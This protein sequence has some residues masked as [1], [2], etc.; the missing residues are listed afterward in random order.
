MHIQALNFIST[1]KTP[2]AVIRDG[3]RPRVAETCCNHNKEDGVFTVR[4]YFWWLLFA[5][6]YVNVFCGVSTNIRHWIL[7]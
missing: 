2:I 3:R 4:V 5:A 7:L 1:A 6:W